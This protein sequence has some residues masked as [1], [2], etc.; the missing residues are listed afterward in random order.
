M[1]QTGSIKKPCIFCKQIQN[2]P[3]FK[4]RFPPDFKESEFIPQAICEPCSDVQTYGNDKYDFASAYK[5]SLNEIAEPYI[6]NKNDSELI[7]LHTGIIKMINDKSVFYSGKPFLYIYGIAGSG[8]TIIAKAIAQVLHFR[9]IKAY[10]IFHSYKSEI[11]RLYNGKLCIDDLGKE[12]EGHNRKYL[13]YELIDN[14]YDNKA[15]TIITTQ[16][17]PDSLIAEYGHDFASRIKQY[18]KFVQMPNNTNW[19]K[20]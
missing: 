20:E 15:Y 11:S 12:G 17:T 1:I 7:D 4:Q 18:S 9:F 8:K 19:R 10:D 5:R 2:V 14:R 3:V 16:L 6:C 13:T